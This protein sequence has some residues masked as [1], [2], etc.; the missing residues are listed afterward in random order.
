[1]STSPIL[2]RTVRDG[3]CLIWQG[4]IQ[5]KG[6]GSV[7]GGRKGITKLAHRVIY[8]ASVGLIPEGMTIDH[9]C[10]EKRCLNVEHMEVVT[11]GENSRRK[12]IRQTHCLRGHLLGGDNVRY[13]SR[14]SG[15][16]YRICII[17]HREYNRAWMRASRAALLS[18]S[19][20]VAE[21]GVAS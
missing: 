7:T 4:A 12:S 5:S 21:T 8:E 15:Y 20:I 17:C 14:V 11:R 6:Y 3:D 9:L 16:V 2:A 18:P 19:S 13:T 1:M 10:Q